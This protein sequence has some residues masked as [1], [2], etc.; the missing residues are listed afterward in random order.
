[1]KKIKCEKCSWK[2]GVSVMVKEEGYECPCCRRK[3][4][5]QM[6]KQK[7]ERR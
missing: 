1:M 2:W 5:K 4:Y 3:E 6:N 7:N